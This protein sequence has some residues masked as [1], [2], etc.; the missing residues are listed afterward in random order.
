MVDYIMKTD[1]SNSKGQA[2]AK[3]WHYVMPAVTHTSQFTTT[4]ISLFG[5]EQCFFTRLKNI[6]DK[7][8]LALN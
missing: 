5:N 4:S 2:G 8:F 3:F 7:E 6:N 1:R